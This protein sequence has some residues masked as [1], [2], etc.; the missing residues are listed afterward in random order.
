MCFL[1][2]FEQTYDQA[3]I[4]EII[5]LD[6]LQRALEARIRLSTG[7]AEKALKQAQE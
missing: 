3:F 1:E 6:V 5:N 7:L 2:H 4:D